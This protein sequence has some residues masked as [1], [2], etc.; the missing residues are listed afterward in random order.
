M[1][2]GFKWV[3]ITLIVQGLYNL[4]RDDSRVLIKPIVVIFRTF[5]SEMV[6]RFH[7]NNEELA[8][9][10][11]MCFLNR[12]DGLVESFLTKLLLSGTMFLLFLRLMAGSIAFS[13]AFDDF[14][15]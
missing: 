11:Q 3:G 7:I 9:V 10:D 8:L 1:I 2:N 4:L 12:L 6:K 5:R 15:E 13:V 14:L